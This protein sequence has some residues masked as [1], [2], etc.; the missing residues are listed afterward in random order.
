MIS[1]ILILISAFFT[2]FESY[3]SQDYDP[4]YFTKEYLAYD[5]SHNQITRR[6]IPVQ[7]APSLEV[8]LK[9]YKSEKVRT[10]MEESYAKGQRHVDDHIIDAFI[11]STVVEWLY[12]NLKEA[13]EEFT[14]RPDYRRVVEITSLKAEFDTDPLLL[15]PD[16]KTYKWKNIEQITLRKKDNTFITSIPRGEHPEQ[17][18]A[19]CEGGKLTAYTDVYIRN[20]LF[21]LAVPRSPLSKLT[22]R[23]QHSVSTDEDIILLGDWVITSADILPR[24]EYANTPLPDPSLAGYIPKPLKE[25]VL[26]RLFETLKTNMNPILHLGATIKTLWEDAYPSTPRPKTLEAMQAADRDQ[27]LLQ[28]IFSHPTL[29]IDL[30]FKGTSRRLHELTW[31][32]LHN[33]CK[34]IN[35]LTI[36]CKISDISDITSWQNIFDISDSIGIAEA[37]REIIKSLLATTD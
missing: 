37:P 20:G 16:K 10:Y 21:R 1:W 6:G 5:R 17:Q 12:E 19:Y 34:D 26:S 30:G 13:K 27:R 9:R 8:E 3:A 14:E 24:Y 31:K 28:S 2:A 36:A 4:S 32:D 22:E 15:V 23:I 33:K 11:N 25:R 35:N 7:L 29:T 18:L